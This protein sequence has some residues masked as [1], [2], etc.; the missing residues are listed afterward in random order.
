MKH[1]YD[2]VSLLQNVRTGNPRN[3]DLPKP[4]LSRNTVVDTSMKFERCSPAPMGGMPTNGGQS[5]Y[6]RPPEL[7]PPNGTGGGGGGVG[8]GSRRNHVAMGAVAAA[9]A[10]SQFN[11][12][13]YGGSRSRL[14][15]M[16]QQQ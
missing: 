13:A 5:Q 12:N 6:M 1:V 10:K 11:H 15:N 8:G 2:Q 3:A 9:A 7:P 16:G 4:R 14:Y